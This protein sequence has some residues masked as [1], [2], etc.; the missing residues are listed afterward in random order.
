MAHF[1]KLD[2]DNRVL[3]IHIVSNEDTSTRGGLEREEHGIVFLERSTGH[4]NWKQCSYNTCKGVHL[5]GGTPFRANY[6]GVGWY[7]NSEHDIFHPPQPFASHILNTTTGQ[8]DP[9]ISK[10][11]ETD[12]QIAS[13]IFYTWDEDAYQADNT[14]GWVLPTY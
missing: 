13:R 1:A 10:P 5:L 4:L 6:P 3:E 7:Y 14:K 2:A 9:P 11:Q 12:E 8:W